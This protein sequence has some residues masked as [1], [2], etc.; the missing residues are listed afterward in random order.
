MH[1][2]IHARATPDKPA[3][4]LARSGEVVTY[5]ELDQRS[6]RCAHMLRSRGVERGRAIA[7]L[8]VNDRWFH[9]P[10]WA[11]ERAGLYYTPL[12]THLTADE[13]EYIA[14]D[15]GAEVLIA[16][17]ELA[18]VASALVGRLP[19]VHTW[20]MTG[21]VAPGFES[22]ESA[23]A[24]QPDTPLPDE[25]EGQDMLYSSGTTGHPKGIRLPLP[26]RAIGD[27]HPM[28]LGLTQGFWQVTADDVYLSPAPLYHSAPL[29]C[30][31]AMQRIGA[32]SVIMEKFD[33]EEAL[34]LIA[35][36]RVTLSQWVPTMFVRLLRLS[37]DTRGRYD[38]SSHRLA[39]HAAAPCPIPV[40]EQM[41]EWWGAILYEYY[42]ATEA[43]GST[44]ISSDEWLAHPGSVGQPQHCRVHIVG[45]DG[46]EL[47]PGEIG[48][49]YFE[50]GARFD[51]HNDPDKTS[52][53]YTREGW[54][55]V[56]D[57]GRVDD[58]GY[59]YLTDRKA[60][61][62][63]TGGVNVYPQEAENLLVT[64]PKVNDVAVIGVPNEE[65]GEEVKAVVQ[66]MDISAAGP[67]LERELLDWCRAHLSPVKCPRSVDFEASLPRAESG[68]LYKRLLRDRYW[69][70]HQTQ[71]V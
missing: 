38:L 49:V 21:G 46:Q 69:K 37:A 34:G 44:S 40:K 35:R 32:T 53:S 68:K 63:I 59:L 15:C 7:L 42:A 8:Q 31:M 13:I 71:I 67:A 56:G 6:N 50:G 19:R 30:T 2:T 23:V 41:I 52:R 39:V 29:R 18:D 27:P 5:R 43:N 65:F 58:E 60:H 47:A 17:H 20:L 16:S 26:D 66:P 61:M 4:V 24:D 10:C 70:G 51:Y 11:A 55:T 54:S 45:D 25:C 36:H 48:T 12:S 62:I 33:P 57:M 14:T 22:Y 64:H 9:E 1:P 3:Y 28:V